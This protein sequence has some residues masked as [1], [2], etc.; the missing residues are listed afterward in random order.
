MPQDADATF[1]QRP[2]TYR[3]QNQ[4]R[5]TS[6]RWFNTPQ[7]IRR[8]FEKFPLQTYPINELPQRSPRK[9]DR[10]TLWIF[11]SKEGVQLGAPSFNPGCLKWQAYMK[12]NGIDFLTISSNNH[13]SPTGALPF[14]LPASRS[15][16]SGEAVLP[17]PST[18]IERWVR[19]KNVS[20]KTKSSSLA[21]EFEEASQH[22][23]AS[24]LTK[25]SLPSK[26]SLDMRYEA[27]MSLLNYRIRSAYV[28]L[29]SVRYS[30]FK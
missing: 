17:V 2:K 10:N 24:V 29:T 13:A 3:P 25:R 16:D 7:P 18:R 6:P 5:D 27:Y 15:K 26:E 30:I 20:N 28:G 8:L 11:S 22:S 4:A 12:F 1:E 19:E 23:G 14:L 21:G 9:R